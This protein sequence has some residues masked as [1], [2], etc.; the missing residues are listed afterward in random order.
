MIHPHLKAAPMPRNVERAVVDEYFRTRNGTVVV[1][2]ERAEQ[3]LARFL[4]RA[5]NMPPGAAVEAAAKTLLQQWRDD[6]FDI[7][8]S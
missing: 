7:V 1:L 3:S 4:C 8:R 2:P 5:L 6:G